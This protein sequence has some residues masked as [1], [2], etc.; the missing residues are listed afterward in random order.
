MAD[1]F[2]VV[3]DA[4]VLYPFAL[5][6]IL[7]ELATTDLF[8]GRWSPAIHDEWISAVLKD[9][10]KLK[11]EQL[12][13]TRILM[14]Q[15]V[16]DCVVTGYEGLIDGLTMRD[17][18]DRHVLAAAI[19]CGAQ[20]IVTKN[21]KDFDEDHLKKYGVEAQHPDD[22]I[23]CLMDLSPGV[24]C[25]ALKCCR[26]RLKH[27]AFTVDEYLALLERQELAQTVAEL[28]SFTGVL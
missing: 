28:R 17:G 19:K 2:T 3:F 26:E 7:V 18:N 16:L 12:D 5:R 13:R 22:F 23:C 20:I 9:N 15:A 6:D 4:C 10:P 21:L 11:R 25:T 27:P 24:V 14:D 8:R 1:T